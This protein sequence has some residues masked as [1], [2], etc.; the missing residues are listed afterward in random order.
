MAR[1]HRSLPIA[2]KTREA[3]GFH[4]PRRRRS[5]ALEL[6]IRTCRSMDYIR[7]IGPLTT[8]TAQIS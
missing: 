3:L 5:R 2:F 7:T 1:S 4:I 8:L 6:T